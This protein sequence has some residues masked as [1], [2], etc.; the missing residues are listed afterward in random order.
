[1]KAPLFKACL[2]LNL[3]ATPA[4]KAS[5]RAVIDAFTFEKVEELRSPV[6]GYLMYASIPRPV[7]PG[8]YA[9]GVFDDSDV[10]WVKP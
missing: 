8:D 7:R 9:F 1:V 5:E 3:A 2:A 6:D 4:T 10:E